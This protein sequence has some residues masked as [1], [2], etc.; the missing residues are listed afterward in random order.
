MPVERVRQRRLRWR[1][2]PEMRPPR[3]APPDGL[4]QVKGQGG[5]Q[6]GSATG[7]RIA[8]SLTSCRRSRISMTSLR[9]FF[10]Y[11]PGRRTS[12]R[13][14][15]RISLSRRTGEDNHHERDST[16]LLQSGSR[17]LHDDREQKLVSIVQVFLR[18]ELVVAIRRRHCPDSPVC[19]SRFNSSNSCEMRHPT[20]SWPL[21][22]MV[23]RDL[24]GA[25][26]PRAQVGK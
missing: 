20:D 12:T 26:K 16:R 6:V 11:R 1:L 2:F 18:R 15:F 10:M 17:H 21:F 8:H 4:R 5:R 9:A 14:C 19:V 13:A 7:C 24:N 25:G 23:A 22:T 3:E